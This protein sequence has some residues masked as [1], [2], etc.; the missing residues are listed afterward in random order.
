MNK[1]IL[2]F[3]IIFT[4]PC[5]ANP[6]LLKNKSDIDEIKKVNMFN[7]KE[8]MNYLIHKLRIRKKYDFEKQKKFL[9]YVIIGTWENP[10]NCYF[11]F[12]KNNKF[13]MKCINQQLV[14]GDW[15]ITSKGLELCYNRKTE[16]I[17]IKYFVLEKCE[18]EERYYFSILKCQQGNIIRE[19]LKITRAIQIN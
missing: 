1:K 7:L 11:I 12:K 15:K 5:F 8:K 14:I 16:N 19:P 13:K 3:L 2:S 17:K 9:E 10:P 4:L 6:P 18:E